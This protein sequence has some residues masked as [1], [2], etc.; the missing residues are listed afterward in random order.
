MAGGL[1]LRL[2][3]EI[4]R[5]RK[6]RR[7]P[8]DQRWLWVVILTI[9][10]ESPQ[11]G[12]L[13]LAEGVP[14]TIDDLADEAA[15][16]VD[17]VKAGLNSFTDQM[18]IEKVNGVWHCLKWD[19]RQFSSDTS[20]ERVQKHR[21]NKNAT[22]QKR[23]NDVA[24]TPPETDK[25][26]NRDQR[27]ESETDIK[28]TSAQGA[29]AAD[30]KPPTNKDLINELT[31]AYRAVEG[32]QPAK[33]DHSFIG[34]LY[35]KHGYEQVLDAINKLQMAAAT[36]D[37]EK[38]LLYLKGIL[39]SKDKGGNGSGGKPREPSADRKGDRAGNGGKWDKLFATG[40]GS[41][42]M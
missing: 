3:A 2:Y 21:G 13:L 42:E 38:P 39:E 25:Q 30:D 32:I 22:L 12:W 36:Q 23:C 31:T 7:L 37:L 24:E 9:A 34:A 27:S 11:P 29:A 14:V 15:I 28:K 26:T 8:T 18:M 4:R 19:K 5:D 40:A 41:T 33:G 10:K 1:W 6:L 16:P 17:Q 20:T 35:N